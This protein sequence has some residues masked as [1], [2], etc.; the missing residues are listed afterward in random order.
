MTNDVPKILG[1]EAV[2]AT[3]FRTR[4]QRQASRP[5]SEREFVDAW[6]MSR[7]TGGSS[8][9]GLPLGIGFSEAMPADL[10]LDL[11]VAELLGEEAAAFAAELAVVH[12]GA[13][14]V[15]VLPATS[16]SRAFAGILI[17][18]S[19]LA[20]ELGL[21]RPDDGEEVILPALAPRS[22]YEAVFDRGLVPIF[23]DV[24]PN[25]LCMDPAAVRREITERTV[26][27]VPAHTCGRMAPVKQIMDVA[28]PHRIAVIEDCSRAPGGRWV[29]GRAAGGVGHAGFFSFH[30]A[31]SLDGGGGGAVITTNDRLA[32]EIASALSGRQMSGHLREEDDS[33]PGILAALLRAQ[34][35]PFVEQNEP[36]A[37]VFADLD[38]T[39]EHIPGIQPF[40]IEAAV[41][42]PPTD[43]GWQ[44]RVDLTEF[45][46][47][48]IY[49]FALALAAELSCPVN[50]ISRPLTN[51]PGRGGMD[52]TPSARAGYE[53]VIVFDPGVDA[54]A[55]EAFAFAVGKLRNHG[56]EIADT[57]RC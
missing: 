33:M 18:L 44:V 27:I 1:G 26:A 5:V 30:V 23:V 7:W 52:L 35:R 13:Q 39:A 36:R 8:T 53:T 22:T 43:T 47:M 41:L 4:P 9:L 42:M 45:G 11:A 38:A 57:V 12:A 6:L 21:R 48:T 25:G 28:S 20:E 49:Q 14:R 31:G 55:P 56:A 16:G 51:P 37:R 10:H 15:H 24:L 34:L 2:R 46:G 50:R 17:T 19:E 40:P 32:V 54:E 29:D 3:P